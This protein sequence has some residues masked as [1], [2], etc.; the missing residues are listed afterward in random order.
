MGFVDK[1]IDTFRGA[2]NLKKMKLQFES[3]DRERKKVKQDY[4]KIASKSTQLVD[5]I[6]ASRKQG[7]AMEVDYLWDEIKSVRSEAMFL[8]RESKRSNLEYLTMRR[9]ITGL[10]RLERAKDPSTI[11]RFIKNMGVSSASKIM[12]SDIEQQEYLEEMSAI[13]EAFGESE[14]DF[15]FGDPEKD[16]FLEQIDLIITAEVEGSPV[17]DHDNLTKRILDGF[18]KD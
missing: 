8:K 9:Y 6:M 10:E 17:E 14:S 3:L 1:I 13:M 4:E 7:D 11:R 16:K 18:E 5:K 12:E 15:E 2:P